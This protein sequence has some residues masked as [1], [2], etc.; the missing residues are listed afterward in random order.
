ML[1]LLLLLVQLLILLLYYYYYYYYYFLIII[2]KILSARKDTRPI[3]I[4]RES[5]CVRER[6]THS[7]GSTR[8][9]SRNFANNTFLLFPIS[10]TAV[11]NTLK[12]GR[13]YFVSQDLCSHLPAVGQVVHCQKVVQTE[14]QA[15]VTQ[16]ARQV[17]LHQDVG[18]LQVPVD[19]GNLRT[20][21]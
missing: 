11:W 1:L 7:R 18:A 3:Q 20:S 15:K 2:I 6:G 9:D 21:T 10:Y 8:R 5:E 4:N 16:A 14:T 17:A 19:D 12:K 13:G